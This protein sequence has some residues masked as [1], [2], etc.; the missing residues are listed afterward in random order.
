MKKN[1]F[2][3][4]AGIDVPLICGAM[5]PCSNPELVAAVSKAGGLGIVQPVSMIFAHGHELRD[6]IK[7]IRAITR[8]PIGFNALVEKSYPRYEKRM[9][10]WVDIALEEEIKFFV[11]ALGKPEW[12]VEKVHAAGGVVYHDVTEG[13][14]AKKALDSGVDG[15]ICVND[16]AGGHAGALSTEKL[17]KEVSR[18]GVP[19]ICAGGISDERGFIKALETGYSGVQMG[20][21]FIATSECNSHD[22]YKEAIL[23]AVETDIV[24]TEKITGLPVSVIRTPYVE[25]QGVKAGPLARRL[26]RR[27]SSRKWMRMIYTLRSIFRLRKASQK[28]KVY[29]EYFQ[30]G[31]S[32]DGISSVRPASEIVKSFAKAAVA[33]GK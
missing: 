17:Y 32:V 14:W 18:F 25:K 12:V 19:L 15:L 5:Y 9:R 7:F 22:D 27:N 33:V 8:K 29:M 11:T 26:L 31:K 20:T 1:A 24:L 23:Q 3:L 16:R 4:D 30:A 6:G 21:R 28:G 2:M 13:K 10:Q